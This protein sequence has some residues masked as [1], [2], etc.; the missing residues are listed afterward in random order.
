M[1]YLWCP[2]CLRFAHLPLTVYFV[3][4]A[5]RRR[6][7]TVN[8]QPSFSKE[9]RRF[10][11]NHGSFALVTSPFSYCLCGSQYEESKLKLMTF[12]VGTTVN[13]RRNS[14]WGDSRIR[15]PYG[16]LLLAYR[17][18]KRNKGEARPCSKIYVSFSTKFASTQ[19]FA[20]CRCVFRY[21]NSNCPVRYAIQLCCAERS[22]HPIL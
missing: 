6:A 4:V 5:F 11:Y 18:L 10:I 1:Q 16:I 8:R 15:I 12:F 22:L 13:C 14:N 7:T 2:L 20:I 3:V 19:L 9:L 21:R 17:P